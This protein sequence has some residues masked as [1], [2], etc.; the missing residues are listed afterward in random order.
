ME[1]QDK[2]RQLPDP[3]LLCGPLC[4]AVVWP[5][6]PTA[7][8][9]KEAWVVDALEPTALQGL[10]VLAGGWAQQVQILHVH[11]ELLQLLLQL[12]SVL[13]GREQGGAVL[14]G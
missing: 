6:V 1:G 4:S 9:N 12:G 13:G 2:V 8:L 3:Q 5:E 7:D 14:C 10:Q 11:F